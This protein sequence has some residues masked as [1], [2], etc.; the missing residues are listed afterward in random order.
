MISE[1]CPKCGKMEI[2]PIYHSANKESYPYQCGGNYKNSGYHNYLTNE[3][4]HFFCSCGYDWCKN[5]KDK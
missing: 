2:H 1:I 3:H 4:L 5:T